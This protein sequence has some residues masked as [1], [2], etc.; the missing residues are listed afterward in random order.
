MILFCM[1]L[2]LILYNPSGHYFKRVFQKRTIFVCSRAF[3]LPS[4]FLCAGSPKSQL[5]RDS[6]PLFG[7]LQYA[8]MH[9]LNSLI[10][11]LLHYW[12]PAC[13]VVWNSGKNLNSLK[14]FTRSNE[15]SQHQH[16]NIE[17]RLYPIQ[18]NWGSLR[19][20]VHTTRTLMHLI[21]LF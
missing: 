3:P 21:I 1:C 13:Y 18:Q 16:G 19:T 9:K 20:K 4:S 15:T 6:A 5:P 10:R 17:M 14:T 11:E 8:V 2:N 12:T 7:R